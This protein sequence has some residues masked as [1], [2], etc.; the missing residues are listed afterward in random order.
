M[1]W[2]IDPFTG[3]PTYKITQAPPGASEVR[4]IYI[5]EDGNLTIEYYTD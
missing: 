5:D 1:P 3:D 2:V 4:N